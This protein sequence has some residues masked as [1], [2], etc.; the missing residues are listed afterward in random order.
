[1]LHTLSLPSSSFGY[2]LKGNPRFEIQCI[3]IL[4]ITPSAI[5]ITPRPIKSIV[6]P[7]LERK[8]YIAHWPE[9]RTAPFVKRQIIQLNNPSVAGGRSGAAVRKQR[10]IFATIDQEVLEICAVGLV[11]QVGGR[12]REVP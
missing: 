3:V 5:K 9:R 11:K 8:F 10:R 1:M 4:R 7:V 12:R 6:D 2:L